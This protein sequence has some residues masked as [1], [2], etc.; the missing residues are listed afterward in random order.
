MRKHKH[1]W[2]WGGGGIGGPDFKDQMYCKK[3]CMGCHEKRE[4][5]EDR[6]GARLI[7]TK[8]SVRK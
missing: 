3:E 7:I 4:I 6:D 2:I 5:L 8:R 1:F